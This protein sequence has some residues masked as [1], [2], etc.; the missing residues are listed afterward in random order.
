MNG[1]IKILS[2]CVWFTITN[3]HAKDYKFNP[4][5]LSDG[6]HNV[7]LS[8]FEKGG[9][10]PGYYPVDIFLNGE[11]ID[12]R[13]IK[14]IS[15]N[16]SS[17]ATNLSP[18]LNRNILSSYGIRVEEISSASS[19]VGSECFS[20][21][22]IPGAKS[23]L[24]FSQFQ[25]YLNVPQKYISRAYKDIAPEIL[26]DDGIPAFLMNYRVNTTH[27]KY[28]KQEQAQDVYAQ[29]SPGF[30][31]GSWRLRN[32]SIWEKD[33]TDNRHWQSL[34]TYAER[35]INSIKS[36]LTLGES[37]TSS[38]IF[39]GVPFRG[40]KISSDES[41][42]PLSDYAYVPVIRGV[43]RTQARVEIKQ[44]G[45]VIYNQVVP[46]GAFEIRD[47]NPSNLGGDLQVKV[48]ETDG[49]PQ[50]FTVPYQTPAIS[51]K[52]GRW[53]Y[54][55]MAGQY[56]PVDKTINNSKIFQA[57]IIRGLPWDLTLYGGTQLAEHYQSAALGLGVSLGDLGAISTDIQ[58]S[59]GQKKG[60]KEESG[61][62]FSSK[63]NKTISATNTTLAIA[64]YQYTD[65]DFYA[66][67]EVLDS[68]RTDSRSWL[69]TH[70]LQKKNRIEA[71]IS[72]SFSEL[73]YFNFNIYRENYHNSNNHNTTINAGY[74]FPVKNATVSLNYSQTQSTINYSKENKDKIFSLWVN[75]PLS[76][77]LGR[78]TYASYRWIGGSSNES[79]AI[80][81]SGSSMEQRLSWGVNQT[82]NPDNE[83]NRNNGSMHIDW[84]GAYGLIS[85]NYSYNPQMRQSGLT[86]EGGIV[87]HRNGITIGQP[88][89]ETVALIEA[90]GASNVGVSG[91]A[92]VK[93]DF[94]GYTTSSYLVPY[95][96][97]TISLNPLD[98]SYEV[99]VPITDTRVV[100]T[101]GA[102][103]PATFSTNVGK[104]VIFTLL[105]KNGTA[106][107]FGAL[108]TLDGHPEIN[109][110][111]G[112]D[113]KV[114]LTGMPLKGK[115][116][117]KWKNNTYSVPFE[118]EEHKNTN[119][120]YQEE[121]I[122]K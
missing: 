61:L 13:E 33:S 106:V 83:Y 47:F 116:S 87:A 104:R 66:L 34:K 7:D 110:I 117:I 111:V 84:N 4:A 39:D 80:G 14:F 50:V 43:A 76:S 56:R 97:N 35:G 121:L 120:T 63:Y 74:T 65:N 95:Q 75:I 38:T 73:G 19:T 22:T 20:L 37:F 96:E 8:I 59:R 41:M 92:G 18:C 55:L 71:S 89:S 17:D 101:K 6:A 57:T 30:N 108:A 94:R 67:S 102:I 46:A 93:T 44:N 51:L 118:L 40:I 114:Y 100:P 3:V 109:G 113:G 119:Q 98:F 77:S 112:K 54:E 64:N 27:T 29:V 122:C 2:V 88:L 1:V 15:G 78:N 70:D 105:T 26:W 9:Q 79:H 90:P 69:N 45:Y 48:L 60:S 36:R 52:E 82:Y 31:F 85:G 28:S 86:V 32:T 103:V 53:W 58:R 21:S 72:Q 16:N 107:P 25:L 81:L 49:S 11:W 68:W 115:I 5:L 99:D 23:D 42:Y 10:L 24:D 62:S 91:S 12:S